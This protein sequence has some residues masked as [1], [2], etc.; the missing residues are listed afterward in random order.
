MLVRINLLHQPCRQFRESIILRLDP[1]P[2]FGEGGFAL[3]VG[4]DVPQRGEALLMI[5]GLH[6]AT[7]GCE[8]NRNI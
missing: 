2:G 8:Q 6:G 3:D 1:L 5:L 4:N 7:G